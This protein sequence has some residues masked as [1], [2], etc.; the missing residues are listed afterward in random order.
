VHEKFIGIGQNMTSVDF[1]L[2]GTWFYIK[3]MI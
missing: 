2:G 1:F 3:H